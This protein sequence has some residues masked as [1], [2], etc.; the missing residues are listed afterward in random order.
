MKLTARG[1]VTSASND[2]KHYCGRLSLIS[3]M[4]LHADPRENLALWTRGG[5]DK[6]RLQGLHIGRVKSVMTW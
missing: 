5:A 2:H 3:E 6:L 4:A 1:A